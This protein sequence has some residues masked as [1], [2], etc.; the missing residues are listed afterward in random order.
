MVLWPAPACWPLPMTRPVMS[1]I[2]SPLLSLIAG[3]LPPAE[4]GRT[5]DQSIELAP[6]STR[7]AANARIRLFALMIS[8]S[9]R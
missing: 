9:F 5:C 1:Q 3:R 8:H 6:V 4:D 7:P 2:P